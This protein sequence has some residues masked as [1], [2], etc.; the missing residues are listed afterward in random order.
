MD[1]AFGDEHMIDFKTIYGFWVFNF[2]FY[3]F[4]RYCTKVAPLSCLFLRQPSCKCI[5]DCWQPSCKFVPGGQRVLVRVAQCDQHWWRSVT[6]TGGAV[7]PALVAQCD[8]HWWHS[9]T[10]TGGAVWPALVVQYDQHWW[11]SV[12]MGYSLGRAIGSWWWLWPRYSSLELVSV[13][14]LLPSLK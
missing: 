12:S 5:R 13:T 6:S 1:R 3:F 7:W 11:R 9:F 2:E 14:G 10:S 8:Q 4:H